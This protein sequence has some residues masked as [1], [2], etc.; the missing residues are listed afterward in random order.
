MN[1]L[2]VLLFVGSLFAISA[3]CARAALWQTRTDYGQALEPIGDHVLT[4]V[5]Q[6]VNGHPPFYSSFVSSLRCE[7]GHLYDLSVDR[8]H[9]L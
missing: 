1:R 4:E 7:S 3:G 2:T 6:T 5:G 8:D 9:A